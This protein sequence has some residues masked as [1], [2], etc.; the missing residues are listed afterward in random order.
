MHM[1]RA[2]VNGKRREL[3]KT[4]DELKDGR[5]NTVGYGK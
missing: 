5:L 1:D 4:A 2:V 3:R